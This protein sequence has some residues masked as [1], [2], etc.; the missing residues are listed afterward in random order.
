V[1]VS[2]N[3]KMFI[4]NLTKRKSM[5]VQRWNRETW[6]RETWLRRTI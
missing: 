1:H 5:I 2:L 6:H 4:K 3:D